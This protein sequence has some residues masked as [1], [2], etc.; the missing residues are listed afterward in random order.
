MRPHAQAASLGICLK[1]AEEVQGTSLGTPRASSP[2]TQ[3]PLLAHVPR[4][5]RLASALDL[6]RGCS[7]DRISQPQHG[8]DDALMAARQREC[9]PDIESRARLTA[10]SERLVLILVG[11]PARGKSIIANKLELFLGWRGW[12]TKA[13][14]AGAL[15][16]QTLTGKSGHTASFFDAT[17]KHSLQARERVADATMAEVL[18]FFDGGGRIAIFDAS[19]TSVARRAKLLAQISAHAARS[20]QPIACVFIE[21]LLES[22]TLLLTNMLAKVR[23]SPDYYGLNEPSAMDDLRRRC[24]LYER[25]YQSLSVSEGVPFIQLYDNATRIVTHHVYGRLSSS[26]IPFL[27][28]VHFVPQ[29][30]YLVSVA[31]RHAPHGA[32]RAR[33]SPSGDDDEAGGSGGGG[34]EG[35]LAAL[36]AWAEALDEPLQLLSST[37]PSATAAAAAVAAARGVSLQPSSALV[38]LRPSGLGFDGW[39]APD[40]DADGDRERFGESVADLSRRVQSAVLE[41]EKQLE[42]TLVVA[43]QATCRALRAYLLGLPL[44]EAL[45]AKSSEGAAI[46]TDESAKVSELRPSDRVYQMSERLVDLQ[47]YFPSSSGRRV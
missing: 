26:L 1:E 15:R 3:H 41:I 32:A 31:P 17:Q 43:H 21:L 4:L 9:R 27:S 18:S 29:P 40:A 24:T 35:W 23:A 46:L 37:D 20:S 34:T 33:G 30:V 6:I 19:N 11:L 8:G 28:A 5:F 36:V 45:S 39:E 47:L 14:S 42:P 7:P 10:E 38:D 2:A 25:S 13:F 12:Q 44:A 22:P 16:R